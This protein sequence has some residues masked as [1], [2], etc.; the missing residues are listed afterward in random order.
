MQLNSAAQVVL[1][2]LGIPLL[3]YGQTWK[4]VRL[5]ATEQTGARCL[6]G[7]P[8]PYYIKNGVGVNAS[9]FIFFQQARWLVCVRSWIAL[10]DHGRLS[11]VLLLTPMRPAHR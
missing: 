3:A 11:A 7:S 4:L 1:G 6:D 5:Q 2:L 8:G 9:N 10:H